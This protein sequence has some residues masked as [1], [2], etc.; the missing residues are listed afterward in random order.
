MFWKCKPAHYY[1][2]ENN[3]LLK[4]TIGLPR[5]DYVIIQD[6]VNSILDTRAYLHWD[7]T[8]IT[9]VHIKEM[10]LKAPRG[11]AIVQKSKWSARS[12]TEKSHM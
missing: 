3:Y 10:I 9:T 12:L 5:G 7:I 1:R 8:L 2:G 6:P 4:N 11:V